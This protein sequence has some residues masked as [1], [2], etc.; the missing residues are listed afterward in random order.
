MPIRGGRP[1][2][3]KTIGTDIATT[4]DLNFVGSNHDLYLLGASLI[5]MTDAGILAHILHTYFRMTTFD[6]NVSLIFLI[7]KEYESF[8]T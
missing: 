5:R 1:C 8:L 2:Y 6:Y 3:I 4:P 7:L